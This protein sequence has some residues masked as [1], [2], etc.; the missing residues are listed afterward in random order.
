LEN[1][2]IKNTKQASYFKNKAKKN[3]WTFSMACFLF[4][5]IL[6]LE[7]INNENIGIAIVYI[8]YKDIILKSSLT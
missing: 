7:K 8:L 5:G 1:T 3:N 4:L 6:F 2:I